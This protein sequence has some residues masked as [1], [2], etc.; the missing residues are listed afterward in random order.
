MEEMMG[1][2][3]LVWQQILIA[4]TGVAL[5]SAVMVGVFALMGLC[6]VPV[7]LGAVVGTVLTV[8]NFFVMAVCA[9]LAADKAAQQ[10]VNGAKALLG[11]SRTGRYVVLAVVLFACGASGYF[12]VLA[13]A[14][15]LAFLRPALIMAEFFKKVR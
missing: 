3:K 2:R 4:A 1:Y 12:H 13:L 14:L 11:S 15:P 9:D 10:D 5:G 7:L 6:D 8:G